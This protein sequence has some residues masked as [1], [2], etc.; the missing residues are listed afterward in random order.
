MRASTVAA[1]ALIAVSALGASSAGAMSARVVGAPHVVFDWSRD[2]C[3]DDHYPDLPVRAFRDSDGHVQ[4]LLP[5]LGTRRM[6][7]AD[8][9]RLRIDCDPVLESVH[10]PRPSRYD[11]RAWL[12]AVWTEDGRTVRGLVHAEYKGTLH[13]GRCPGGGFFR[14]WQNSLTAVV[15][16]DGGRRFTRARPPAHLV[17][18]GPYRYRAGTGPAGVFAP[19][20]IVRNPADGRLYAM[21][22]VERRGAQTWGV[23]LMRT[24]RP[25][26]PRSWRAWD[27]SGFRV[28]FRDPYRTRLARRSV[29]RPVARDALQK[30]HESL[31]WNTYLNRWVVIGVAHTGRG[32][33]PGVRSGIYWS[34]SRDLISWTPRRLLVRAELP[35]THRCG[36]RDP[37]L[38]PSLIDPR[39]RRRNFDVSGRSALLFYTRFNMHGC[40]KG[41]DRDLVRRTVVFTRDR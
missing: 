30:V 1:A 16:R 40:A 6:T 20:N 35:W 5:H 41:S 34:T 4:L 29:C 23:C 11:D 17:A 3:T 21:V 26:D 27:G 18:A 25:E 7:G 8:L 22:Q 33:G 12:A 15:S 31:T 32:R 19:S 36:D 24:R 9:R 13:R 37:V 38:Y 2:A 10:D 39:S 28:R 14:C